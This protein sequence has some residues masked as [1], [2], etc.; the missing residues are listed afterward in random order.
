MEDF[1]KLGVFYLGKE[2]DTAAK[3]LSDK[4]VLY[5]SKDMV[6]H[7]VCLGMT[8]SGKTGLCLAMLEEAAIDGIPVIAIDPKG[9]LPNLLLTF[10]ELHGK[11][12]QPWV[13]EE[14]ARRK[15]LSAADYAQEQAELWASGLEKWGQNSER[16]KKLRDAADFAVYTP[17]ST[18]GI[19]LSI[20]KSFAVPPRAVLDDPEMLGERISNVV[21]SLLALLRIDADPIQ[22]REHILLSTILNHAWQRGLDLDLSSLILA[23]QN[24]PVG[25]IGVLDLESFFPAKERF[26]LAMGLNNL[27]ASPGFAAWL[28]GSGLEIQNILHSERGKPRV[29]IFY[30]AHLSEPERMFF[31]S[32][33]LNEVVSWMR[34]QSGTTSLRALVYMDEIFGYF[35]P[36]A[37]PPSKKPLLTLLKQARAYGVGVL[38]ATQNPVDLDYKG[39]ANTGTWF[40]GRLQTERDKAR[41]MEALEGASSATGTSFRRSEVEQMLAGLGNRVFILHNTH[42]DH[43]VSFQTRWVMSYLRGPLARE[44]VKVLMDPVRSN[45]APRSETSAQNSAAGQPPVLPPEIKSLFVPVRGERAVDQ[46]LLLMP[47]VLGAATVHIAHKQLGIDQVLELLVTLSI[48][49]DAAALSWDAAKP[50]DFKFHELQSVAPTEAYFAELPAHI[51]KPRALAALEKS[52]AIWL[53]T[54]QKIDL[55]RSPSSGKPS[56]P[57]ESERDFRIRLALEGREERD[58]KIQALREKYAVKIQALEGRLKAAEE[59]VERE[60][61]EAKDK[62]FQSFISFGMAILTGVFGRRKISATT[63][64]RAATAARGMSRTLKAGD[65]LQRAELKREERQEELENMRQELEQS[66]QELR[67]TIDPLHEQ[68][69]QLTLRPRKTDCTVNNVGLIWLPHWRSPDG[70]I[71]PAWV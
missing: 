57:G 12:F 14:D 50:L 25:R 5:D 37:N 63:M 48:P 45:F 65:D 30:I 18:A 28:Q 52:F 29:S 19:P 13:N 38:L 64:G 33:L 6:T 2:Y 21:S 24:P 46:E 34:G 51:L 31:V 36:V 59:A 3:S 15:G 32:L 54:T 10:P 8:G 70:T 22:S 11:H 4:L 7:G 43:P 35:P 23:I 67:S 39:L 66:V 41:V 60:K 26:T 17:G 49:A 40:I 69:E 56:R 44:Q 47:A 1:E 20:L 71:K 27:M 9:D 68:L 55:L 58:H 42:E 53:H 62:K 61:A 16:I